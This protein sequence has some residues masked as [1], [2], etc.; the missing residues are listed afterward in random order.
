MTTTI[1]L[2]GI[3]KAQVTK[4]F[5][6]KAVIFGTEEYKLWREFKQDFPEA[7]MVTKSIKRN[8]NKK[9]NRNMTYDRMTKFIDAQKNSEELMSEFEHQKKIAQIAP[10]P[11]HAIVA[12]FI[13]KFS[14]TEDFKTAFEIEDNKDAADAD[15][16]D[17]ETV[18]TF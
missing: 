15:S 9:T 14:D 12:W 2:I 4:A 1:K 13:K 11:Y 18:E 17:F 16:E 6:K 7:E 5:A 8:P 10:S 3:N